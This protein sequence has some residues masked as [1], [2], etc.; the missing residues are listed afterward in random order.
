MVN[1]YLSRGGR[2]RSK[3]INWVRGGGLRKRPPIY[4]RSCVKQKNPPTLE[5]LRHVAEAAWLWDAARS[6][7]VW[8]NSAGVV[9]FGGES[10]FDLVDRPF[11]RHE[12]GVARIS[13]LA[14]SLQPG[15]R[16]PAALHF[17][18]VDESLDISCLCSLH[19]LADGRQGVLVVALPIRQPIADVPHSI[20][21]AA[22]SRLPLAVLITDSA[23]VL[24]HGNEAARAMVNVSDGPGAA[25]SLHGIISPPERADHLLNALNQAAITS[26][27]ETVN[28]PLGAREVRFTLTR[29][30]NS[31]NLTAVLE[32]VTDRRALERSLSSQTP[33]PIAEPAPP[34]ALA[35]RVRQDAFAKL[36]RS[37]QD[38]IDAQ[39]NA[40]RA[41]SG[42]ADKDM[43]RHPVPTAITAN[44]APSEPQWGE[45][46]FVPLPVR[47]SL[48][49]T[50]QAILIGRG[51]A[52]FFATTQAAQML[53]YSDAKAL[54]A[55]QGLWNHVQASA[56]A[57]AQAG[58][59]M[60]LPLP[61]GKAAAFRM[62]SSTIP[63]LNGAAEQFVL[64][65]LQME[66]G[67]HETGMKGIETARRARK[68]AGAVPANPVLPA[69][70]RVPHEAVST[71]TA[72]EPWKK[73]HISAG[74]IIEA[75]E[76][77]AMLDVASDGI[78]AL[79]ETGM[80]LSFS[81]GA[82]AIFGMPR[83]D[84][85]GRNLAELLAPECRKSLRDYLSALNGPGLASV[86]ND[87]REFTAIEK[88]GGA[89]PLFVTLG[90]LQSPHSKAAYCAVVR[91]ITQWKRTERELR[92]AKDAA[93]SA[94]RQKSDF[95]AGISHEIRTPLNAILGFSEVMRTER[96]G[97]IKN[98]KYR[99]YAHDIHTSGAHLLALVNDLLDL[100]KVEAG[101][102]ELDFTAVSIGDVVEHGL[103]LL[104]EE[105][106]RAGIVVR[107]SVA[108]GL[109]RVVA[110][111]RALR[112]VMLNLLSNA[113]KYTDAGGQVIISAQIDSAGELVV[114]IK[115]HGIGMSDAQLR[116]ALLPFSRVE[117]RS[118][119][120]Q[121]TGLGLPLSKALVEA[122]RAQFSIASEPG[123]G[124]LAEIRF[125]A[126]RVLAE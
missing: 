12:A 44:G 104:Q 58:P 62:A 116:E 122:N 2:V 91:D 119:E 25:R 4:F 74:Q 105:A 7:I 73:T 51:E 26:A 23:G 100:S 101:K 102:M 90:K 35:P 106:S 85:V 38:S 72:A 56:Q 32:D 78:I 92:E 61:D 30:A 68:S 75:E 36:A 54:L 98:D 81:A 37:L 99:G 57:G 80:I 107:K 96:F 49:K 114:R 17:P 15:E 84:V 115:D 11:D 113:I 82:E 110:D 43:P 69:P 52:G 71:S 125:P 88:Q 47:Q 117:S 50:G 66:V 53:G 118:R 76:L 89:L 65:P 79:D 120:R 108:A 60:T 33:S 86:F 111:L 10:V 1:K 18:S 42:A 83:A 94:S 6:R 22:L 29:M 13:A 9:L 77:K 64:T 40:A 48:E 24:L 20:A 31:N 97:E 87:G 55:D 112:Q 46:Q 109:P 27:I 123:K 28:G 5:D 103:R 93:E 21:F 16:E 63:W 41:V 95:L 121:G 8:A 3:L 39:V 14:N 124:T 126:T 19:L 34:A 45:P 67:Q 70:E 59:T